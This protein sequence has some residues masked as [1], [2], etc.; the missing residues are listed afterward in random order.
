ME[1]GRSITDTELQNFINNGQK[2]QP[3]Q[4]TISIDKDKAADFEKR[5]ADAIARREKFLARRQK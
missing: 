1:L 2:P 5:Q 4:R 3:K